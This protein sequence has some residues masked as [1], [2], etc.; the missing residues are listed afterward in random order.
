MYEPFGHFENGTIWRICVF[1]CIDFFYCYAMLISCPIWMCSKIAG[2]RW[3]WSFFHYFAIYSRTNTLTHHS[4]F[5]LVK[6]DRLQ[7]FP[8]RY[9]TVSKHLK[10]GVETFKKRYGN[11]RKTYQKLFSFTSHVPPRHPRTWNSSAVSSGTK[12]K[13]LFSISRLLKWVISCGK[14][15]MSVGMV[16]SQV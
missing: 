3:C 11:V 9:K 4:T 1:W 10:N 14:P 13:R 6:F 2:C 8:N 16:I 5:C 12:W 7:L 15:M